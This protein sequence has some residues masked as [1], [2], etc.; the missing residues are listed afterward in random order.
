MRPWPFVSILFLCPLVTFSAAAQ[1]IT[2]RAARVLDGRGGTMA[3]PTLI[4]VEGGRIARISPA[5]S[6]STADYDLGR[7]TVLP[8]LIDVHDHIGWHFTRKGRTHVDGDGET[9]AEEALAGAGNAWATLL[10]GFTTVQSPGSASDKD[11]R[12]AIASGAIPGPRVL[13]SLEPLT[14]KT[15]PPA[16]MR[17]AVRQR[18]AAGADLIKLFA[19]KSIRDGGAPTMSREQ[20]D[21]ACG[22]ARELHLRTLVHAHSPESMRAA[23]LAGCSQVEHGIFAT[24]EALQLLSDLGTYFDP[25]CSLVFRNYLENKPKFLGIGNYTEAGFAAMENALPLAVATFK[26]AL[27]TPGLKV[28]FGTDAVAGAHG[29]NV[30]DLVCRV[31]L[32]GQKPMDAIVSA[33]SLAA[34]SLG[35]EEKIGAIAPGMQ[36]DLVAVEGDPERDVRALE[37]VRFVM[38]EGR[39]FRNTP[40]SAAAPLR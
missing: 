21:A 31:E 17:E 19:S 3:G 15:G 20:L 16:Q 5:P 23:A 2:I 39:V 36:A 25:Q 29:G 8:G 7:L 35:L 1:T 38:K 27:A 10:A 33:T 9:A 37:R 26:R 22:Q 14:E 6:G 18:A 32:G 4:V 34:R 40:P 11:L 28:V 24:D 30:R 13:T 12:D